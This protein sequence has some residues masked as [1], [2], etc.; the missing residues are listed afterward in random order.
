MAPDD[1]ILAPLKADGHEVAVVD[2]LSIR[3][4]AALIDALQGMA[5]S[6]ASIEPYTAAVLAEAPDLRVISRLGVGY[7]AI[8]VDAAT[9][10]GIVVCT[11]PGAN[12]HS[13]ADLA[14]GLI[15]VCLR[16]IVA[17][18]ELVR[19]GAWLP[20]WVGSEVRA[21]TI[22]VVGAGLIGREV[23]K[24]LH[25]FEPRLLAYDVVE[26]P[27]MVER[28]GV[29]YVSLDE[30]LRQSD[31]LTLHAPLL[32][33]TRGLIDASALA[34]MKP[35]AYVVNTAR[36]PLVDEAAITRALHAGQIAGAALDVFEREPL[37]ASS[38][39]RQAPNLLLTPHLAGV[40]TSA[41]PR[42]IDHTTTM[43]SD[44]RCARP[45]TSSQLG[46]AP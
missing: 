25:G 38:P 8:D 37:P 18:A 19:A 4:E 3:T 44:A 42:P 2:S 11:T 45:P 46:L 23:I 28:F 29:E 5:A 14:V 7:D 27:E 1:R 20:P 36:G 22:G 24:R 16:R 33:E 40:W 30:L 26:S 13:V 10:R 43:P 21:T 17:A 39:L 35:S 32:P 12:H 9:R 34:K 31:V 15:L 41:V 6:L